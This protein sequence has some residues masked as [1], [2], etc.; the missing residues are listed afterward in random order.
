[1]LSFFKC[2][3][4]NASVLFQNFYSLQMILSILRFDVWKW[5][6]QQKCTKIFSACMQ[7]QR[8]LWYLCCLHSFTSDDFVLSTFCCVEMVHA[9]KVHKNLFCL[10]AVATHTLVLVLLAF[11]Q[12]SVFSAKS[13]QIVHIVSSTATTTTAATTTTTKHIERLSRSKQQR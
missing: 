2:D 5:Y 9:T 11:I 4:L 1:M 10:H 8:T 13:T 6:M 12:L 3:S 7:S